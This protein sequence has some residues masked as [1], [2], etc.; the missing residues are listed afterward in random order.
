MFELI[1][2]KDAVSP[3]SNKNHGLD[4][5]VIQTA[6]NSRELG[7]DVT[8]LVNLGSSFLFT[9]ISFTTTC[10]KHSNVIA[11]AQFENVLYEM[12]ISSKGS[13]DLINGFDCTI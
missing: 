12:F 11:I 1:P 9:V 13:D 10:G 8:R 6:T 7:A 5:H 2:K 3:L 4:F